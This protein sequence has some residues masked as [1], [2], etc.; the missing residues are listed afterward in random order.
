MTVKN[1]EK[2]L[3]LK[4][5]I[6]Q[7]KKKYSEQKRFNPETCCIFELDGKR[8]NLNTI[9]VIDRLNELLI[10]FNT[11]RLSA[12]DLGL[13][14][15]IYKVNN[16]SVTQWMNDINQRIEYVKYKNRLN[17]LEEKEKLLDKLLS[18]DKKTELELQSI[19]NM[20][21]RL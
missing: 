8:V 10:Y 1:D 4:Q 14:P 21:K 11:F 20:L 19:E 18:E 9:G 6:E 2:I 15:D 17:E 7:A 5:L 12:I 3:E 13:S 16:F